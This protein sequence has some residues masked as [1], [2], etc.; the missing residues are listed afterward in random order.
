MKILLYGIVA[1]VALKFFQQQ[2]FNSATSINPYGIYPG[3]TSQIAGITTAASGLVSSISSIFS[4]SNGSASVLNNASAPA[5][6][7]LA[8]YAAAEGSTNGTIIS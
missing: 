6:N 3:N 1:Y 2:Q 7:S 4:G 8:D 5:S